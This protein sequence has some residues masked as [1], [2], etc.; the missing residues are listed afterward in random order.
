MFKSARLSATLMT[1][2]L[3][4]AAA[5]ATPARAAESEDV[6][7]LGFPVPV[8]RPLLIDVH[9]SVTATAS[10]GQVGKAAARSAQFVE[11]S[12]LTFIDEYKKLEPGHEEATRSFLFDTRTANGRIADGVLTGVDAVY[13][14]A[15]KDAGVRVSNGGRILLKRDLNWLLRAFKSLGIWLELPAKA[16]V[17][18][19]FKV[20]F[21]PLATVLSTGDVECK[22]AEGQM[23]LVSTDAASGVARLEGRVRIRQEGEEEGVRGVS[24]IEGPCSMEVDVKGQRIS[25]IVLDG[26][27]R[28]KGGERGELAIDGPYRVELQTVIGPAIADWKKQKPAFRKRPYSI[29]SLGVEVELPAHY[30]R[31]T[32]SPLKVALIRTVD[33]EEGS[34]AEIHVEQCDGDPVPKVFF[35]QLQAQLKKAHPDLKVDRVKSPLGEGKVFKLTLKGEKSG[36]QTVRTEIYPW[37]GRYLAFKLVGAPKAFQ[38]ALP[39]FEKARATLAPAKE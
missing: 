12:R 14:G 7:P 34:S 13:T 21:M 26:A 4:A 23:R 37:Q 2:A 20:D 10:M 11:D 22:L 6:V 24:E 32:L 5:T 16:K 3:L 38:K 15:G 8:G 36:T 28:F 33:A 29:H 31:V 1:I 27:L 19:S 18:E 39:E 25:R 30:S 35:D 9:T 17:G